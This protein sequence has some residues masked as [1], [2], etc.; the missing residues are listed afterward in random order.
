MRGSAPSLRLPGS[1]HLV[2]LSLVPHLPN[3]EAGQR[4]LKHF[5]PSDLLFHHW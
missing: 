4:R 5:Y 1:A 3:D 2:A